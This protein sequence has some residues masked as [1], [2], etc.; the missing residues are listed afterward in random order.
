MGYI[1][2]ITNT[3]NGKKYVGQTICDDIKKR[4]DSHKKMRKDVLGRYIYSAYEKYG[5]DK[6][7]FQIICIC[8]DEDANEY[9]KEYIKK[10]N[11]LVPNGYNLK[12]GG[13]NSK[14]HP[15]TLKK[16]SESLTGRKKP[17]M[18]EIQR[19]AL[20]ERMKGVGN[21]N[22]G[23]PMSE[24]QKKKISETRKNQK[25]NYIPLSEE[26]R[27]RQLEGLAKGRE[28]MCNAFKKVGQYDSN[29]N[30]INTFTNISEASRTTQ[31]Y[32]TTIG[33]VCR[34]IGSYKTAGGYNW[35]YIEE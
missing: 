8:F 13:K 30:L 20:S 1:Y 27:K 10:F 34:K 35:K 4:W 2:L 9:E 18:T 16:M 21:H 29:W 12:E 6:F 17:P 26:G 5:I 22:F 32:R 19:K 11:T 28:Y 14:H 31:V 15:E 24:E 25:H 23:K 7:K 3:V 33:N